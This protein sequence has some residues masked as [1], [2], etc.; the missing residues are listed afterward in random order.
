[1][2]SVKIDS[3][4]LFLTLEIISLKKIPNSKLRSGGE[5]RLLLL[6]QIQEGLQ[7]PSIEKTRAHRAPGC[8]SQVAE[9]GRA[10]LSSPQG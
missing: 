5:L 8:P 9:A 2:C 3:D 6:G 7:D 10:E 4:M 1:M